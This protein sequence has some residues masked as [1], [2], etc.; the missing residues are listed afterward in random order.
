MREGVGVSKRVCVRVCHTTRKMGVHTNITECVRCV[1]C[2]YV[3]VW[4]G[5]NAGVM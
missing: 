4:G 5:G 2:V 1:V 3:C